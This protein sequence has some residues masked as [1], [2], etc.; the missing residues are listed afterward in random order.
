MKEYKIQFLRGAMSE[1]DYDVFVTLLDY[2]ANVK[3]F[4]DQH[5]YYKRT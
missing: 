2:N 3:D 4:L 1:G 5:S